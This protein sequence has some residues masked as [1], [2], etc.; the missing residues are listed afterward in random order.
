LGTNSHPIAITSN[1]TLMAY[2]NITDGG[3]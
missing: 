2:L 1:L 3:D